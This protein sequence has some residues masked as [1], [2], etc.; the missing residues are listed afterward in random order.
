MTPTTLSPRRVDG[1]AP[2]TVA[3]LRRLL[4]VNLALNT[5]GDTNRLLE[6]I[7]QTATAVADCEAASI[8]LYDERVDA[9]RFEAASGA[10]AHEVVGMMVPLEGSLAGT[11][12]SED[13]VVYA[14]DTGADDRHCADI[15]AGTGFE[16]RTLLGVPMRI[17]GRPVGVLEVLNPNRGT[18]DRDDAEA[19][20]VVAAQAAVAIRN[21]RYEEALLRLNQKLADL[22]RL[23]N[24]FL[25]ITS[26]E[27]RTPLTAVRGFGQILA[28]EV[29]DDLA[30]YAQAVVR[31]GFRM[32]DVVETLDVMASLQGELGRH[33]GRIVSLKCLLM[34]A[35]EGVE[36]DVRVE[37][38]E[39]LQVEGHG[40]R[41]RLAF[42]NLLRNAVQ[43]SEPGATVRVRAAEHEGT[44]HIAIAD[45]GRG[46]APDD[47]ERIFEAYVQVSDPDHRDH[48]GLGVGL[49]VARAIVVRHG[50]QLWAES[51]GL[52]RGATFHLSL[53]LLA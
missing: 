52:G 37:F 7:V 17:D 23:K 49:T 18:F 39:G 1:A 38:P 43:F 10:V 40:P 8:L 21:A 2:R 22:D 14:A 13:R 51:P 31:A 32:T 27:M 44:V 16:T 3:R 9:L 25:A 11:I 50:G 12:F 20:L 41:I 6:V 30:P 46:I 42:T 4:D 53:P 35:A 36:G 26:H 28:D 48:E 33:P 15:D 34:E 19:L 45:E 5:F 47:L 24:N 29:G